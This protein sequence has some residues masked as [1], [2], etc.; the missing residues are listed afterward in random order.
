MVPPVVYVDLVVEDLDVVRRTEWRTGRGSPL[1][2][3]K[4]ALAVGNA[5]VVDP[6]HG[7]DDAVGRD[8]P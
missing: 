4:L 1:Y 7:G 3:R 8:A 2:D 6:G 5:V